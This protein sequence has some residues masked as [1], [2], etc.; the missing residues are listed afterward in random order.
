VKT[1]CLDFHS[2]GNSEGLAN[3]TT[4]TFC[5]LLYPLTQ[6]SIGTNNMT[7]LIGPIGVS[8]IRLRLLLCGVVLSLSGC[9]SPKQQELAAWNEAQAANTLKSY[10]AYVDTYSFTAGSNPNHLSQARYNIIKLDFDIVQRINTEDSYEHFIRRYTETKTEAEREIVQQ[11]RRNLE[12]FAFK[13]ALKAANDSAS[14]D[15]L[16]DFV[17]EFPDGIHASEAKMTISRL[18]E[19]ASRLEEEEF[20]LRAKAGIP[21]IAKS[22]LSRFPNSAHKSEIDHLLAQEKSITLHTS[23]L[24]E[25][26][27]LGLKPPFS[28]RQF[29]NKVRDESAGLF[30]MA[31]TIS[32][33][34]SVV[35]W[36]NITFVDQDT[37]HVTG[38]KIPLA[39]VTISSDMPMGVEGNVI[40]LSKGKGEQMFL[41]DLNPVFPVGSKL[42]PN[43]NIFIRVFDLECRGGCIL[44]QK[45]G[46]E[47]LPGTTIR[48]AGEDSEVPFFLRKP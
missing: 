43:E 20:Y 11:A 17:K 41:A 2:W 39:T 25:W 15:T 22:F 44:V 30:S 21:S 33:G 4:T 6:I 38:G 1:E 36:K 46:L 13:R 19:E 24:F 48:F 8:S 23:K 12:P 28:Q 7:T 34:K 9:V 47:V 16:K 27:T 42:R 3:G 14:P 26:K 37:V 35:L 5:G 10:R 29:R 40:E 32:E 18:K 31:A 45:D